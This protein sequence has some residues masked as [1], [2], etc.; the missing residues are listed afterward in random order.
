MRETKT[1]DR[2][3]VEETTAAMTS[4]QLETCQTAQNTARREAEQRSTSINMDTK[5]T[6]DTKPE[7]MQANNTE[8]ADLTAKSV[9]FADHNT[10]REI[11][12][13]SPTKTCDAKFETNTPTTE[14]IRPDEGNGTNEDINTHTE[15]NNAETTN[16]DDNETDNTD[17]DDS[18]NDDESSSNDDLSEF[19]EDEEM[20]DE[21]D[22]VNLPPINETRGSRLTFSV[23]QLRAEF[24]ST[25]SF[26]PIVQTRELLRKISSH[27]LVIG[28]ANEENQLFTTKNFPEQAEAFAD[29]IPTNF[30]QL[31][32]TKH[33]M[34]TLLTL[35]TKKALDVT[36]LK[37]PTILKYLQDHDIFVDSHRY[38]EI[39]TADVG[40]FVGLHDRIT[41]RDHV[42]EFIEHVYDKQF[43]G[44]IPKFEIYLKKMYCRHGADRAF[45][46][47]VAVRCGRSDAS[48]MADFLC[49]IAEQ[50]EFENAEFIPN[51]IPPKLL[52]KKIQEQN[53]YV[54]TITTIPVIGLN[55]DILTTEVTAGDK[56]MTM[57]RYILKGTR[58]EK[59]EPT[60]TPDRRLL[61]VHKADVEHA[62]KFLDEDMHDLF[63]KYD[64]PQHPVHGIPFRPGS[65]HTK[66]PIYNKY[67]KTLQFDERIDSKYS[68]PPLQPRQ[69]RLQ[70]SYAAAAA[71][72]KP[73]Q[74]TKK[75]D[76][77]HLQPATTPT[78]N[79]LKQSM[80]EQIK[81]NSVNLQADLTSQVAALQAQIGAL[82]DII[83]SLQIQ[84]QFL[85][86]ASTTTKTT[87]KKSSADTINKTKT[88]DEH[89]ETSPRA[90]ASKRQR[91]AQPDTDTS[92]QEPNFDD[93]PEDPSIKANPTQP[94]P[95]NE[96]NPE[97]DTGGED[98]TLL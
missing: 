38:D 27:P 28:C 45:A 54:S 60:N 18:Y 49:M 6:E 59:F 74:G 10:F 65:R 73:Q 47:V 66:S 75:H 98:S 4:E 97:L 32:R 41:N 94:T 23:L 3:A 61:I 83:N 34:T 68:K 76:I 21:T 13:D 89:K 55:K 52:V 70:V 35:A 37:T 95:S 71:R 30:A 92:S 63:I 51:G 88:M 40:F 25:G 72:S 42:S 12:N 64:L 8:L 53:K 33:R 69:T 22:G 62:Q 39:A 9:Y 7:I 79:R 14:E 43:P 15:E 50:Q 24:T 77:K 91:M 93:S 81:N 19:F 20:L 96:L 36:T 90:P 84:V 1:L 78:I 85:L 5:P 16:N 46:R 31:S 67:T 86:G 26:Q 87:T 82:Q 80:R 17:N 29:L 48:D 57:M 56:K 2:T 58:E 44:E 11:P